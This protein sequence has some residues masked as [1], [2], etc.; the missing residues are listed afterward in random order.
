M[1]PI[2]GVIPA[3]VTPMTTNFE[4][5][6]DA[7]RRYVKWMRKFSGI[8]GVAVNADAGE[9]AH[10]LPDEKEEIIRIARAELGPEKYIVAG[11]S[12]PSTA[13]AVQQGMEAK[14]SGASA[15]LVFS[16]PDYL[17][18]PL[19]WTVPF[20]Y[21]QAIGTAT[22]L[23]LI[24]FQLWPQGGGVIYSEETLLKLASLESIT[25]LKEASFDASTLVATLRTLRKAERRISVL[26]GS[27]TIILESFMLGA[28]GALI[29]L[30]NIGTDLF[31]R[32]FE[33]V[34]KRNIDEAVEIAQRLQ[35]T[36]DVLYAPPLRDYRARVKEALALQGVIENTAVR[37]PL[38]P[39][40]S[41]ERDA[42]GKALKQSD[43]LP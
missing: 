17:T 12:G 18:V 3:L 31:V 39:L 37:P 35:P 8:S 13:L 19:P 21:H 16:N 42:I 38:L 10:L 15:L 27:D 2:E 29:A 1:Q 32:M 33:S 34:R 6:P 26:T 36:I 20:F 11:V 41:D 43:L 25:A 22:G 23:P 24:V 4:F 5:D 14:S 30:G 40:S 7:F 28:D 9:G